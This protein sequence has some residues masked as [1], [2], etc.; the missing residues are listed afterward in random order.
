MKYKRLILILIA[1]FA[2]VQIFPLTAA[3]EDT[4]DI[5]NAMVDEL[6]SPWDIPDAPGCA[7]V[8]IK[9]G[10]V[11][12]RKGFGSANLEYGTP[13][14]PQ[15]VFDVASLTKQFT[16]MAIAMLEEQGK[17]SLDDDIRKYIPEVPYF[18]KTIT[19]RYLLHHT[20]GLRDWPQTLALAGWRFDDVISF[21]QILKMVSYQQKL[22]FEPGTKY[23]Y[24]NTGY[25][26]LAETVKRVTG[27]SF[28]EWTRENIFSPLGMTGTHVHDDH[29]E[30]VKNRAYSYIYDGKGHFLKADGNLTAP[31][32]SSLYSTAEDLG[33]W[34]LNLETGK[35]GGKAVIERMHTRGVLDNGDELHYGFGLNIGTYKDLKRV[36]HGG[37]WR[38]FRSTL[39]HYPGQALGIVVLCNLASDNPERMAER[40]ADIYLE[41]NREKSPEKN[42]VIPIER[43]ERK[44][45]DAKP[46]PTLNS[47]GPVNTGLDEQYEGQ[48]RLINGVV[49]TIR[50]E[51]DHLWGRIGEQ[52]EFRLFPE[53]PD[54]FSLKVTDARITFKRNKQGTVF[55]LFLH[56]GGKIVPAEKFRNVRLT[57]WE[58]QQFTGSY[59]CD[60]LDTR[61][62]I[63]VRGGKLVATHRRHSDIVLKPEEGD[64]FSS[65]EA[66]FNFLD[67][68]RNKQDEV[69]GFSI[70][71][72][73]VQ[74]IVFKKIGAVDT[75]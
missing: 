34:I 38:G 24:S 6:L 65:N 5:L 16:G 46:G 17:I 45:T 53:S 2:A 57:P 67:F 61:Y 75:R 27:K 54:R 64:R 20:S 70:N 48:Y 52:P 7:V 60:E 19:L 68:S 49:I 9:D 33:K 8:V 73:R 13:I 43:A 23:L 12:Y 36:R 44:V 31:G 41:N 30:I 69:T 10:K 11:I 40:I 63:I 28:R 56:Q 55:Q 35:V 50:Q 21:E 22:N 15:T 58:M 72:S 26:L 62:V 3:K 71:G 37:S 39:H 42:K 66:F 14:T 1:A 32:S 59:Y 47:S 51:N 18:G 29:R 25:N 4:Y 74:N